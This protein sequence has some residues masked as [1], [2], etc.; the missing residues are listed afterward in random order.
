MRDRS[1]AG[2]FFLEISSNVGEAE[3]TRRRICIID[4]ES[5]EP[6]QGIKFQLIYR[7]KPN[8]YDKFSFKKDKTLKRELFSSRHLA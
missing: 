3:A 8:I 1:E 4:I 2:E 5:I 6:L 7:A